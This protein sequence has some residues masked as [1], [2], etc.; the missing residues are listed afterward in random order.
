MWKE[1]LKTIHIA[2]NTLK[3]LYRKQSKTLEIGQKCI[4]LFILILFFVEV[5]LMEGLIPQRYGNVF[6]VC[7]GY[8]SE[9]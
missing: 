8:H 1:T 6:P 3:V 7:V 5:Y 2:L 9:H 4:D